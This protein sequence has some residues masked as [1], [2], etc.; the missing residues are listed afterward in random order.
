MEMYHFVTK[1][2]FQA[3]IERVWKEIEDINSWTTW[4]PDFKRS[5]LRGS[6]PRAQLG[7]VA[8]CDVTG[9]IVWRCKAGINGGLPT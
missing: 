1:W 5:I 9:R 8:D 7:S 4:S 6:E 3:P 2:F